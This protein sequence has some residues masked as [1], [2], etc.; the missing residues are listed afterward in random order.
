MKEKIVYEIIQFVKDEV[1]NDQDVIINKDDNIITKGFIDSLGIVKLIAFMQ[2]KY[3]ISDT[4]SN[5]MML[6]NF[7]VLDNFRTVEKIADIVL[8]YTKS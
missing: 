6:N 3:N 1:I 7:L 2:D 5:K 4:E 8:S